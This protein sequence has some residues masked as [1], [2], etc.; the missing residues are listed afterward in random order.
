[1]TLYIK[2][3][4]KPD[5]KLMSRFLAKVSIEGL[6]ERLRKLPSW[7]EEYFNDEQFT[8]LRNFARRGE[9]PK[10]WPFHQREIYHEDTLH[11]DNEQQFQ[12]LHEWDFLHTDRGEMYF[13]ICLFGQEYA[14][15]LG[16]PEI[17]GYKRWLRQ[18]NSASPL[19]P[20][21]AGKSFR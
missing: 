17:S 13:V 14:F 18:N 5:E 15:N 11:H 12:L 19:Y 21:L 1:M 8:C 6:V 20:N 10:H 7:E 3:P 9:R 16:G 2:V 4:D